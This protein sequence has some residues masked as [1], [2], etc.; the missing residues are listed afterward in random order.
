MLWAGFYDGDPR[1]LT[2]RAL[3]DFANMVDT[4]IVH[5]GSILGKVVQKSNDLL[6]CRGDNGASRPCCCVPG[7]RVIDKGPV[8]G[9]WTGA[10][11]FF[12][13][14]MALKS[15]ASVV[16]VLNKGLDPEKEWSLHKSV[17]WNYEL[18]TL[19]FEIADPEHLDFRPQL[20]LVDMR[21]TCEDTARLVTGKLAR[22]RHQKVKAWLIAKPIICFDC[23]EGQCDLDRALAT[24][25]RSCLG[26][27]APSCPRFEY[28]T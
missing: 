15:Q 11:R 13:H 5:P 1:G 21:G 14:G 2:Q 17:F 19:E 3:Q 24:R 26:E 9:F 4:S 6:G 8:V 25:V 16:A 28:C 7:T 18:P 12:V 20:L 27:H 23:P 22:Y 10:S